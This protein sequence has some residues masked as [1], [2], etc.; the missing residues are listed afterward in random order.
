MQFLSYAKL[1]VPDRLKGSFDKVR[2]AIERGDFRSADL[3]KLANRPFF[4]A[5]LDYD[6]RLLVRFVEHRGRRACLALELIEH[7]AYD[8]SRFL[9]GAASDETKAAELSPASE[10]EIAAVLEPVR[11]L[12]PARA[13]FHLLD[14]PIS[15]HDRPA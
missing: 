10:A 1:D 9:R 12:H 13:E 6:S 4:R 15:F 14:K 7:H 8:R 5:R 11:Y 2:A 3:K